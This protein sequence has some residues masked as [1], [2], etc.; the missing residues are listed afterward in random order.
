MTQQ[1]LE[2][3]VSTVEE[4]I[5]RLQSNQEYMAET[6][7]IMSENISTLTQLMIRMDERQA[8]TDQRFN[9]L[10]QEIRHLGGRVDNLEE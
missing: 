10:L 4:A 9:I 2:N 3:R 1:P 6:H 7:R 5:I 8:E